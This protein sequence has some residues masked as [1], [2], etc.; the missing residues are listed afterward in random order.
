M[1]PSHLR[2]LKVRVQVDKGHSN[3]HSMNPLVAA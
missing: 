1:T 3:V 2:K